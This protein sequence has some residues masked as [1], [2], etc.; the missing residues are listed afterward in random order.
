MT[1]V[2]PWVLTAMATRAAVA[3][4]TAPVGG[5]NS[6]DAIGRHSYTDPQ[7]VMP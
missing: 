2:D 5:F 7:A 1:A 4:V 6:P 3:T